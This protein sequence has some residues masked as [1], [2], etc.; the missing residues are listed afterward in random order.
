MY[1]GLLSKNSGQSLIEILIGVAIGAILIGGAAAT[2]TFT[3]RSN[4]QNKNIQIASSLSQ[5][6]LDRVTVFAAADW[7]NIDEVSGLV[8]GNS[9]YLAPKDSG[10][11]RKDGALSETIDGVAFSASFKVE[12]VHRNQST[13]AIEPS[14]ASTYE[15]P[16][17]KKII[18]ITTWNENEDV[19]NVT[20]NKYITRSRNFIFQQTDWQ[21]GKPQA[22]FPPAGVNKKFD[23]SA[24]IKFLEA[25]LLKKIGF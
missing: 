13:E 10:L 23:E 12:S 6:M 20:V 18:A 25:G 22:S 24:G 1:K 5:A 3:L 9:Y 17:T 2:I 11:E 7:H 19:A 15:D 4:V 16:S 21:D 14:S 8:P